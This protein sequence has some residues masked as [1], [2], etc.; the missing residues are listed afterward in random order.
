MRRL[1][2]LT[3]LILA[4]ENIMAYDFHIENSKFNM[5]Q[6]ASFI[7]TSASLIAIES[8]EIENPMTGDLIVVNMPNSAKLESGLVL[9]P[10][11]K[12]SDFSVT[13]NSPKESDIPLIKEIAVEMGGVLVGDEG[14]EF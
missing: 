9:S 13:I 5:E 1:I 4:S 8:I 10:K 7:E 11:L 14:E 12:S 6:W 2:L 3:F